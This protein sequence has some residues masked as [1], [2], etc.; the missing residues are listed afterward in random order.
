MPGFQAVTGY[1]TVRRKEAGFERSGVGARPANHRWWIDP[2]LAFGARFL[3]PVARDEGP[4]RQPFVRRTLLGVV[5]LLALLLPPPAWADRAG[6]LFKQARKAESE[7]NDVEAY[8]LYMAARAQD[9]TNRKLVFAAQ[10]VKQR[11]AQT[12]AGVGQFDAALALDPANVYLRKYEQ[13]IAAGKTLVASLTDLPEPRPLRAPVMLEPRDKTASFKVRGSIKSVYENVAEVFGL[14]VIFNSD[15]GG[16]KEIRFEL[17]NADFDETLFALIDVTKTLLVP[18]SSKIFLIAEDTQANRKDLEPTAVVVLPID[19]ALN[20]EQAQQIQQAIQQILDI[21][22]VHLDSA[23]QQIVLRDTVARVRMAEALV[24]HLSNPVAEVLIEVDLITVV[25]SKEITAGILLPGSFPITNFST[26]L[27]NVPPTASIPLLGIGGGGTVFGVA[28]GTTQLIA[29][30]LSST[31][32]LMNSFS[33]RATSGLPADFL[34]GERF[35]IIT[36]QFGAPRTA[37]G[38][39]PSTP[40]FRGNFPSFTF[41][42]LGLVFN[43]TPY[44]HSANE[45]SLELEVEVKQLTGRAVNGL[46]V[47]SNRSLQSYVRLQAGEMALVSGLAL[48]E[49]RDTG[50]G[51]TFLSEIPWLGRLFQRNFVQTRQNHL[52]LAIR[53][54]ILRLPPG[55][56]SPTL[57]FRYGPEQ[58]PLPAI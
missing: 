40:G 4:P 9:P 29:K 32:R 17:D 48:V 58:R 34:I 13:S 54:R 18:V 11:A 6:D 50:S 24:R 56:I 3:N 16:E 52:I 38:T 26:I 27:Q 2:S 36:A 1:S 47:L 28:I 7:G 53:P 39:D 15:Y 46:P 41:E 35:P 55:E 25:D 30:K 57:T 31:A 43:V 5:C 12:L 42:D 49:E 10:G 45:I 44:V 51:V 19:N 23:R 8:L 21:R 33:L 14:A 37:D 20:A 22:R